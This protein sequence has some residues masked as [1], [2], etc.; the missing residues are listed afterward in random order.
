MSGYR[1]TYCMCNFCVIGLQKTYGRTLKSK[2]GLLCTR[3]LVCSFYKF[4]SYIFQ[5]ESDNGIQLARIS[6][7]CIP[8]QTFD[9]PT[10]WRG[11]LN[12]TFSVQS[13]T[14][15]Y[16]SPLSLRTRLRVVPHFSSGIVKNGGLLVLDRKAWR[17]T[18]RFVRYIVECDAQEGKA[19]LKIHWTK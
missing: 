3:D 2:K 6:G 9:F 11:Q 15:F 10:T 1:A 13:L 18:W 19:Q 17:W 12:V 14:W 4:I 8:I 7:L 16:I 5:M